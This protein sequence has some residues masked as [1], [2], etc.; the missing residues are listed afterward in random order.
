MNLKRTTACILTLM[1]LISTFSGTAAFAADDPGQRT[2]FVHA[3]GENPQETTNV[4]TVY[5]GDTTNLYLAV[6][7]PNKGAYDADTKTHLEPQYDMNGYTVKFYFDP[8]Y[9]DY[10]LDSSQPINYTIPNDKLG[11]VDSGTS[12]KVGFYT[13]QHGSDTAVINGKEYK[14]AYATILFSGTYLPQKGSD[15][16]WYN[17]CMLPL[18]PLRTGQTEVFIAADSDDPFSL[19]L[20]AKNAAVDDYSPAFQT[21]V[22][23][24]GYHQITIKDK[25]KPSVP[26][27]SP[28]A[29]GYTEPQKVTLTTEEGCKIFYTTDGTTYVEYTGPIDVGVTTTISCYAE[30][31][32]DGK[33]SNTVS[34]TYTMLPTPPYLFADKNGTKERLPNIYNSDT[35]FQVYV[36]DAKDFADISDD[37]EVYYTFSSALSAEPPVITEGA[38][39][40]DTEWVKVTKGAAYQSIQIDK[41]TIVRL[42]TKKGEVFSEASWY[43]FGIRPASVTAAPGSGNQ[44]DTKTDVTLSTETAGAE[45]YYTTDGSD[46]RENGILYTGTPLTLFKD[47]TL[48]T[49]AKYRDIYSDVTSYYYL[50]TKIDDYGIDAFYPSGVYEGSVNVTLQPQN[51]DNSVWYATDGISYKEYTRGE[52]LAITEDT[53]IT[54][55]AV[56]GQGKKGE[57]YTFIYKIKPL[58][59]VFAPE[60]TQFSAVSDVT[61]YLQ[62]TGE[63]YQLY[64]TTDG[65][66]PTVNGILADGDSV[67]V[68]ITKYTVLS[69]AAVRNGTVYSNVVSHSYDLVTTKPARPLTTLPQGV[70]TQDADNMEG[71][72]AQFMPVSNGITIYYTVG[73]RENPPEDP[74]PGAA[75]EYVPGSDIP[76][77]GETM[78]KAVAVNAFRAKSDIAIFDYT[79][80][81]EAP[82]APPSAA[83]EGE[84]PVIP[85]T[86]VTGSTVHY[87]INGFENTFVLNE[88]TGFYI[89]VK[90]G[91]AYRDAACTELLGTASTQSL[92]A[93]VRLE[94]WAELNGVSSE[95]NQY[96]YDVSTK[97]GTLAAPYANKVSGEYEQIA[98]ADNTLLSVQLFSLN[99][100]AKIEYMI[101]NDG[102]WLPYED[103]IRIKDDTVLLIR[104]EKDGVYSDAVSYVYTFTPLA[105]VIELP[106][107]TYSETK[108]TKISLDSRAPKDREYTIMYRRNGDDK[109][110]RYT[111]A[112]IEIDHTMSIKAYVIED[113]S[114]KTSKNRINY[115]VID[116]AAAD[117]TVYAGYPYDKGVRYSVD[118]IASAPYSEGI[119]LLTVNNEAKIH[120]YYTYQTEDG[121]SITTNNMIYDNSPILTTTAMTGLKITAWLVDEN[122]TVIEGSMQSFPFEFVRLEV[123]KTSLEAAGK[124][125]VLYGTKYTLLNDYPDDKTVLLYYTTDGSDPADGNN[126]TRQLYSG[127]ELSIKSNTTVKAVYFSA[128]GTCV[129]CKDEKFAECLDGVY[130]K[131]GS[132]RYT[133][134]TKISGGG[135][136]GGGS[137]TPIDN[138]RKYT[139]DIFGTE[140]PTHIGYING[141][142]DGSVQAAGKITREEIAAV[143]HRVKNKTYDTPVTATGNVFSDVPVE[144]WSMPEIEYLAHYEIIQGYPDGT[145][146]PEQN[147]TRAEFA[148][149]VRRFAQLDVPK[150]AETVFPDV[151]DKLWAYEDILAIYEAGLIDGYEDGTFRPENEITR[152]EVMT[153]I[154]RILGRKPDEAYIKTLDFNPYTDLDPEQ[155]YY[156]IVLEATITHSYYLDEKETKEYKWE[157]YR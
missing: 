141:Y 49:V 76:I 82:A 137:S 73:T 8:V 120:Y 55:Y 47:T 6:D 68:P 34:Y 50:F 22:I 124:T 110:V 59:P 41:T 140:H 45:I 118:T 106:S 103:V 148:A 71:F 146:Q 86:A 89:D 100:G 75:M 14:T 153:I 23:N 112:E 90:T 48:R 94:T 113:G 33:Q 9:F 46:P 80:V 11:G 121:A 3:L 123:P 149:L 66:D 131:T 147:L 4:S 91:S 62:E 117:G 87:S 29:G 38:D 104:T 31:I 128:C 152:A 133:I 2:V 28:I 98:D 95:K 109:D 101:N 74:V 145:Y 138:T 84:L 65:S 51:P 37:S 78:I 135:G 154:N 102:V 26:V 107:G 21:T 36:S 1:M 142:P 53:T 81:P 129:N 122:E 43:S 52:I 132:Y 134:P 111:G 97:P 155:W 67:V 25:F 93:P 127:E 57:I 70:Y 105:P 20:L 85:V 119:K 44:Y 63:S 19:E 39:N 32:S 40:P 157:D 64:Y 83:I 114:G 69:A 139:K 125:E 88:G 10:A 96:R 116:R 15:E 5:M 54:T 17:L 56:D 61:I 35:P 126:D 42:I 79:I 13:Y 77:T 24:G 58:P 136:G 72:S 60:T 12:D 151:S 143:L 27:A 16:L 150:E 115:Y 156:T 99:R 108:Y 144:R 92:T 130:G 7:D 18:T 30:R